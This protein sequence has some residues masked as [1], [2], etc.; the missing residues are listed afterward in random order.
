MVKYGWSLEFIELSVVSLALGQH[1]HVL[2]ALVDL[3]L[4]GLQAVNEV[5]VE[6][7]AWV[8]SGWLLGELLLLGWSLGRG[9]GWCL[10]RGRVASSSHDRS[11]SLVSNF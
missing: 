5:H 4:V 9:L 3:V 8:L 7:L 6:A 1:V 2:L 10:L 11:N